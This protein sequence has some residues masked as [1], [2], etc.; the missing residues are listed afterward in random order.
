MDMKKVVE[1]EENCSEEIRDSPKKKTPTEDN[2]KME[3]VEKKSLKKKK[4]SEPQDDR[5]PDGSIP[6]SE[7][8]QGTPPIVGIT[9]SIPHT[10]SDLRLETLVR[11]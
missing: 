10:E 6:Q 4:T 1:E 3:N 8:R 11:E 5:Y 2:P 7:R 9:A